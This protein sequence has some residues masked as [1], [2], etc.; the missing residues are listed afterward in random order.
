MHILNYPPVRKLVSQ[1]NFTSNSIV[2]TSS[3]ANLRIHNKHDTT[4]ISLNSLI[5]VLSTRHRFE[6]T[7]KSNQFLK[8]S[9]ITSHEFRISRAPHGLLNR[10][11]GSLFESFAPCAKRVHPINALARTLI[12]A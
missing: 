6:S 10:E 11:A 8:L 7:N 2:S 3:K 4:N 12:R 5:F 9:R 1:S